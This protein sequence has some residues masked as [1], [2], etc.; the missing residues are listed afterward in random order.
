MIIRDLGWPQVASGAM[1]YVHSQHWH[2]LSTAVSSL[3]TVKYR[4]FASGACFVIAVTEACVHNQL[5]PF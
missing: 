1:S 3:N 2:F 5:L 4:C